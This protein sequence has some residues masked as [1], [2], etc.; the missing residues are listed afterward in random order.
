MQYIQGLQRTGRF[1]IPTVHGSKERPINLNKLN[2]FVQTEHFKM[3]GIHMLKEFLKPGKWMTK[4]DLKDTYFMIPVATNHRSC[5]SS[6][7]QEKPTSSTASL[8]GCR[9]LDYKSDCSNPQDNV[10]QD[11]HL[12]R[13]H[14]D[15]IREEWTAGLIFLLENLSFIMYDPKSILKPSKNRFLAL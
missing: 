14:P 7:G 13:Q 10:S 5:C 1:P 9:R 4:V 3:E 8:S 15:P 12:H 6:S 2:S 11:D